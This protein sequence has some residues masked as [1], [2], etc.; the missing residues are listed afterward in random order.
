M[1]M[2]DEMLRILSVYNGE[3]DVKANPHVPQEIEHYARAALEISDDE[4]IM[5]TIRNSFTK[6]HRGLV[7][8]RD[9]I[10]WLNSVEIPTDV[11]RLTWR[12]MSE[13]KPQFRPKGKSVSLGGDT[14]FD[15][16]GSI[17]SP[18]AIINLLDVLVDH[19]DT[20]EE[21]SDGFVFG[22]L[23]L[24]LITRDIPRDKAQLKADNES[25]AAEATDMSLV[26]IIYEFIKKLFS[27]DNKVA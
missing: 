18:K 15:N 9:G 7:I 17:N 24:H 1:D 10:Y 11:N 23:H 25:T 3:N 20:Q 16:A 8:G 19:Y 5:A 6:F 26:R 13:R 12:E 4:Y 27:K 14:V 22:N 21:D 2:L